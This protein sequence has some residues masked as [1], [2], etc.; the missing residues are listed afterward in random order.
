[1]M[2]ADFCTVY[3]YEDDHHDDHVHHGFGFHGFDY[4]HDHHDSVYIGYDLGHGHGYHDDDDDHHQSEIVYY[5][6]TNK[7]VYLPVFVHKKEKKK[8]KINTFYS[9]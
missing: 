5:K 2:S 6:P 3:Q 7:K 1:M 9:I 4:D 8:S